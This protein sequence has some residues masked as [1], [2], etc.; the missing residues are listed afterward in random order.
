MNNAE[1]VIAKFG[2]Q[3]ALARLIGKKQGTVYHWAKVGIIPA[4]WQ[5]IILDLAREKNIDISSSEFISSPGNKIEPVAENTA[6]VPNLPIARWQGTLNITQDGVS[7]YV[8]DDGRRIISRTA[9]THVLTD[10]K[11]GGNLESYLSVEG[12]KEHIPADL[13]GKLVEF[14]I[15]EVTNKKVQGMSAETFIEICKAYVSGMSAGTLKTERQQ[16]IAIKSAMFLSA[17][18]GVGLIALIDEATGYQYERAQDALQVKMKL[19]LEDE[20]RKWEKTFPDKLWEEFGRLTNW[21]GPLRSRPKYWGKLVMELVYGYLDPDV[22]AWLKKNAPKPTGGQNYH[23]WLS[24]QY[25]LKKL[26][27]HLWMLIGVASTCTAMSEL[28]QRMAEKYGKQPIQLTMYLSAP[29]IH[30]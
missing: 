9:A 23:Q 20:M 14:A 30:Q 25:G 28:R 11:G 4:K 29:N 5:K 15:P 13:P 1:M 19:F 8:L 22:S 7:C 10:G 18:A 2:G 26:V 16:Q 21:K 24:S 6:T 17:C 12:V 3:T 27:E